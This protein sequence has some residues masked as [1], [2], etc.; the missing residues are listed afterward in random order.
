MLSVYT[1]RDWRCTVEVGVRQFRN[2]L[3]RWL[4]AVQQGEEIVVTERGRPIA[5]VIG[6]GSKAPLDKLVADGIVTLAARPRKA[7]RE[8][9]RARSRGSVSELVA[10]QR[11]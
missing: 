3:R 6:A 7:D 4:D 2:E 10:E 9:Q 1:R 8:H 5:R 11:R